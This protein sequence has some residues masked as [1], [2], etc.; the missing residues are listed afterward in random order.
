ALAPL[1][2]RPVPEHLADAADWLGQPEAA[3]G[4]ALRGLLRAASRTVRSRGAI[5]ALPEE[6]FPHFDSGAAFTP[7]A[8]RTQAR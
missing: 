3:R 8:P 7:A 6:P 4:R 1:E 2:A 5:R